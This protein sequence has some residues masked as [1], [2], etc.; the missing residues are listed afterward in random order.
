MEFK[1]IGVSP[2]CVKGKVK[3]VLRPEDFELVREGDVIVTVMT[4]PNFLPLMKRSVAIVT[5][6]GGMTCHA[7]ILAREFGKPCIVGMK[8]ATTFLHDGDT[9]EVDAGKGEV[10]VINCSHP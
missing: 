2:G 5:D 1:G 6:E 10:R 3:I 8:S 9:V 4:T 7:A